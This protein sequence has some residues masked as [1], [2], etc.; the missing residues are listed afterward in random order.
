VPVKAKKLHNQNIDKK[1][2]QTAIEKLLNYS[3][4]QD[5]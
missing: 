5:A 1:K 2:N 3:V 4:A